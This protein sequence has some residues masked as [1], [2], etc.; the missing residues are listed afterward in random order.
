MAATGP[1]T[2]DH[3]GRELLVDYVPCIQDSR[4]LQQDHLGS[5]A[6]L[7]TAGHDDK[8]AWPQRH[9][10]FPEL[11]AKSPSPDQKHF[12]HII[13]VMLTGNFGANEN[14]DD[15]RLARYRETLW[16]GRR[17]WQLR[18]CI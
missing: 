8:L 14:Q 9:N 4:R 3:G 13:V 7:D 5:S 18:R 2:A 16:G 12:F 6:M 17:G 1:G 10:P 11:D 15:G